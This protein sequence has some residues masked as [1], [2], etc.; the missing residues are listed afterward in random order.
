MQVDD[1]DNS[2]ESALHLAAQYGHDECVELLIK[3]AQ[4]DTLNIRNGENHT[5]LH[6][7]V[8]YNQP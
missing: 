8:I 2:G 6:L 1:I 3:D 5:P 7:A 4:Q